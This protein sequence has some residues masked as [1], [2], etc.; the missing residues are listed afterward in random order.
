MSTETKIAGSTLLQAA[1][2]AFLTDEASLGVAR[3]CFR[4]LDIGK[5]KVQL[6]GIDTA[7]GALAEAP[8]PRILI[9]DV[10]DTDDPLPQVR[11][12][13]D[14]CDPSTSVLIIGDRNDIVLYREMKQLGVAD[15]QFKPIVLDR[16]VRGCR[17]ALADQD[18]E[19]ADSHLGK[20]VTI[21]GVHGGV[22][23]TTI[24]VNVAWHLANEMSRDVL[25]IDLDLQSGDAALQLNVTPTPTLRMALEHPD[26]IDDVFLDRAS[27]K[28]VPKLQ[29][30]AGLE[31][32]VDPIPPNP[33]SVVQIVAN[34]RQR[35]RYTIVDVPFGAGLQLENLLLA[36]TTVV[37]VADPTLISAREMVRWQQHLK[38][39]RGNGTVRQILNKCGAPGT[40]SREEFANAVG[41]AVDMV[42]PFDA[43]IGRGTNLGVPSIETCDGLRRGLASPVVDLTGVADP[44][45]AGLLA[46]I[47]RQ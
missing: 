37:L 7:I 11:K 5:A 38:M 3:E 18:E 12:L 9:A 14:V 40:L 33:D 2:L 27:I 42:I 4:Q 20:L 23:S 17:T 16:L 1:G 21:M 10:S 45:P 32:L 44:E 46:R 28:V 30:L 25:L 41:T 22:G 47:F 39:I 19:D 36:S 29:L 35:H 6:G 31:P 43:N 26:R 8:S 15:Y 13:A 34:A 24:A